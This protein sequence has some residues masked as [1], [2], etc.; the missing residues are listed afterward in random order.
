MK[1]RNES[2]TLTP[3]ALQWLKSLAEEAQKDLEV[4]PESAQPFWFRNNV[5]LPSLH[6]H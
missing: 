6:D 1:T 3:A 5:D 4:L 2:E